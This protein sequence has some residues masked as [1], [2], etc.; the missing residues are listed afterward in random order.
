MQNR[1]ESS[2]RKIGRPLSNPELGRPLTGAERARAYRRKHGASERRGRPRELPRTYT[3]LDIQ[4][5]R[6]IARNPRFKNVLG[7]VGMPSLVPKKVL[8]V[9]TVNPVIYDRFMEVVPP[10]K[11]SSTIEEFMRQ[12]VSELSP[13][14]QSSSFL[15]SEK[16]KEVQR[17]DSE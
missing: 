3:H 13:S 6:A 2:N 5:K 11:V 14:K 1:N 17:G 9:F 7:K 10:G 15:N 16:S 12:K 8:R 4:R